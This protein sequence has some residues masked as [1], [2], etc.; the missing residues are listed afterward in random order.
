MVSQYTTSAGTSSDHHGSQ[1]KRASSDI[2]PMMIEK[3][4]NDDDE[5]Y[6][7]RASHPSSPIIGSGLDA[8]ADAYST[9]KTVCDGV[10]CDT[11]NRLAHGR[12]SLIF[13]CLHTDDQCAPWVVKVAKGD[14]ESIMVVREEIA[15][16]LKHEEDSPVIMKCLG[17]G[18]VNLRGIT[19]PAYAMPRA[20]CTLA[21]L[22]FSN[23]D[24]VTITKEQLIVKSWQALFELH[25]L[26]ICHG[27]VKPQN[28]FLYDAST[29]DSPT[30]DY[31]VVFGDF[32]GNSVGTLPYQPPETFKSGD[33]TM[34]R[35][36]Y[37]MGVTT[38][39]VLEGREPFEEN[40]KSTPLHLAIKEYGFDR[41]HDSRH[42]F[43]DV[44][45]DAVGKDPEKRPT[46][47]FILASLLQLSF[48]SK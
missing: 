28:M 40:K 30:I 15:F 22:I 25:S 10:K 18:N 13:P 23:Y 48:S 8:D 17:H 37:S 2:H 27:D 33:L 11:N 29:I 42:R 32:A 26:G 14:P 46:S 43:W 24:R 35:D 38:W 39:C 20:L 4:F 3:H 31:N 47:E 5:Y 12:H 19:R 41:C 1:H 16:L 6:D 9:I 34:A 45:K 7:W 44:L 21:D 36:V